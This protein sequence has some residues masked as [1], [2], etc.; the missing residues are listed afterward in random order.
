MNILLLLLKIH[1]PV[2]LKKR[3]IRELFEITGKAF[4]CSIPPLHGLN[5]KDLLK[6]YAL[7]SKEQC[8]NLV[9]ES[10]NIHEIKRELYQHALKEGIKLRKNLHLKG[11][12]EIMNASKLF[13]SILGISFSGKESGEI[14]IAKCYFSK[15][16]SPQ[17][18]G[19][20]SSLDEGVAEGLSQGKKLYFNYK[21][22]EGRTCCK[23]VLK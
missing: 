16:F 19:I 21:I 17:V 20:I 12:N 15:Y 14:A 5:Y 23:A 9:R 11:M 10:K 8:E 13:Y 3:K 18:C 2:I 22:T 6:E 1:I 7:F 4:Q